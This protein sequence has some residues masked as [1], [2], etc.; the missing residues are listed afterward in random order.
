MPEQLVIS[1]FSTGLIK[2]RKPYLVNNDAFPT[3][4]NAFVFR[5]DVRKKRGTFPVDNLRRAVIALSVGSISTSGAG[6]AVVSLAFP[7]TG[8][9]I[10][11]GE[12]SPFTIAIGAPISQSLTDSAGTG[13]LT[14]S[15]AGPIIAAQINYSSATLHLTFSG[16]AASSAATF[17]GSYFSRLPAMGLEDF[18]ISPQQF[19]LHVAFDTSYSYQLLQPALRYYDV[20]FFKNPINPSTNLPWKAASTPFVWSGANYQQ[21][22]T[23]NYFGAMWA[24]N[25][26]P[27]FNFA[28]ITVLAN[29]MASNPITM[30]LSLP[31]GGAL[32]Y[33]VPGD[34][35]W[36][37]EVQG[38]TITINGLTGIVKTN[39]GAGVYTV[40]FIGNQTI[41]GWVN[42]TGIAQLATNTIAGQDGIKW[43]DGDP[44]QA[45]SPL[46][47]VNFAPPLASFGNPSSPKVA[48]PEYLIGATT[49]V[50]FK[51]RLL[52]LGAI[53]STSDGIPRILQDTIVYSQNGT[54]FYM[55][56]GPDSSGSGA[57]GTVMVPAGITPPIQPPSAT[58]QTRSSSAWWASPVG[59]GGNIAAGIPYP[60]TTVNTNEDCL[61]I[62]FTSRK[63]R[64]VYT[65]NDLLPF[66]F[67]S[68]NT[69]LG[70]SATFSAI[71]LDRGG[72]DIGQYGL[73]LTTQY[74]SQ[75]IDVVI[76][77]EIFQIANANNGAQR[78]NA[79][80]DF[81]SEMIYFTCPSI[82]SEWEFPT[83]TLAFNYRE[84]TW[85]IFF[86][87]YTHQGTLRFNFG[88]TWATI[89]YATW[90]EWNEPWG[91]GFTQADY[92]DIVAGTP[93]G[94]VVARDQDATGE[95]PSG[96]IADI[97]VSGTA[98]D[99]IVTVTSPNHCLASG[100]ESTEDPGDYIYIQNCLGMAGINDTIH[101]ITIVDANTFTIDAKAPLTIPTGTYLGNGVFTRLTNY[102]IQTKQFPGFW[103]MGRKTRIGTQKYL[104]Q[105][106]SSGQT[107]VGI[108]ANQDDNNAVNNGPYYPDVN[109][110][111]NGIIFSNVVLTSPEV[112]S[113]QNQAQIWHRQSTSVIGDTVQVGF[114]LSDMQ[115]RDPTL[116]TQ[117]QD[118]VL[119]G[120]ILDLYPGPVLA[121]IY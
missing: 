113:Q 115:M 53:V 60:I 97:V 50:V 118:F 26:K 13:T 19:P 62:G 87:N 41:N 101:Q 39:A 1:N 58:S 31:T 42:D 73:A 32:T 40:E 107:T 110:P 72:L 7:Q 43:Y 65:S 57:V 120:M 67:Y 108:F 9:S 106:T 121:N 27:G 29:Q 46:G 63:T 88:F 117:D 45:A 15:G 54:P 55:P 21:F 38:T 17:T 86:E 20:T 49:I 44:T 92:P 84:N 95:C 66:V 83:Q 64:L 24:T 2:D 119:S 69:E 35:L 23:T 76:P 114:F 61:L 14:I 3:L 36:F 22:W 85:G 59:F 116:Q 96:F 77:D 30:T 25:G 28:N 91:S 47:W 68:I 10:V 5:G 80:R 90:G 4:Q 81:R 8:A 82:S 93:Q 79:V 78:I 70:S 98:P 71:T 33:L 74:E 99:Q 52:A 102:F 75:R 16:A 105:A 56:N 34:V 100:N 37:N 104:F 109:S 94:F 112:P 6:T 103:E 18:L 89:P 111:N 48:Q 11:S 12:I 51:D